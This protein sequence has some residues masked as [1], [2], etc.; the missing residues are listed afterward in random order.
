MAFPPVSYSRDTPAGYPGMIATTEPHFITSMIVAA[1]SGNI[2]FGVGVIYDTVEDTVK[3]PA[4]IGKFA[5]VAVVDRTLP[6]ANG[7]VYKPY[8]QISVMRNG[9]IWVTA[10]VAVAQGDPVYMTPTGGFTNVS[11]S[12]VNQLIENAEWASVTSGTNQLARLRLGVTK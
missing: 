6:F 12:A 9:S 2:P 3:L 1:A 8:D 4:A 5:G 10:L 11:N 7:E